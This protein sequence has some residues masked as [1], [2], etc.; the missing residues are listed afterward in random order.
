M[1][2]NTHSKNVKKTV[3]ASFLPRV[4]S[5]I[6]INNMKDLVPV[7]WWEK[8]FITLF[9]LILLGAVFFIIITLYKS[10]PPLL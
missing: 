2:A 5:V 9:A 10:Y 6:V 4:K 8:V 1:G 7:T 3:L